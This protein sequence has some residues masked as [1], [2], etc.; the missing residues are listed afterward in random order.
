M[1]YESHADLGG[2]PNGATVVPEPGYQ[3]FH[4]HWEARAAAITLAMGATRVWNLDMVRS[5][6]ETLEDYA[7]LSYYQIWVA[8]LMRQLIERGLA[9]PDE[10]AAGRLLHPALAIPRVLRAGDLPATLAR[11]APTLRATDR[12]A[13]FA[14]GDRVRT[15]SAAIVHHT[16][17]PR[18]ALGKTGSIERLHGAH[19]FP[20]THAQG[21][22]EQ[23]QWLYTVVFDAVELWGR[24]ADQQQRVSIDAWE[25]YLEPA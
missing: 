5:A 10:M 24:G 15:R 20:D 2:Q 22:G 4:A 17:L 11:G 12:A 8:A 1:T 16:R 23:P 19:V 9:H 6:R 21:L 13:R 25:P 7:A 14:V 18:Y 3:P